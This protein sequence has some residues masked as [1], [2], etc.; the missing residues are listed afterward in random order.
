[1][2]EFNGYLIQKIILE[3]FRGK[4]ICFINDIKILLTTQLINK[5]NK[6]Y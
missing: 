6:F 5:N 3:F 2:F 4:F 1:M